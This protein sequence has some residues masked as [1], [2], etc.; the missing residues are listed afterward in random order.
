MS[1]RSYLDWPFLNDDHRALAAEVDTA[2]FV[3]ASTLRARRVLAR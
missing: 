1:D 3:S 2:A